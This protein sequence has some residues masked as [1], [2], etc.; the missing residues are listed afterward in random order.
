MS[1]GRVG[2]QPD[3]RD[4][5]ERLQCGMKA[6][7]SSR[8]LSNSTLK[9]VTHEQIAALAHELW[10]AQGCP[11]GSDVDIWLEA[12]RQLQGQAPR[13]MRRDPIP[14]DPSRPGLDEDPAVN[15]DVERE[16]RDVG[17]RSGQRSPTSLL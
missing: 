8:Y 12:E 9:P 1:G 4:A 15:P 6:S 7:K 3:C 11:S 5:R 13:P 17:S 2:T 10:L 14:A 16:L